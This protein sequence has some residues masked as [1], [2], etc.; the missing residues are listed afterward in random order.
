MSAPRELCRSERVFGRLI[1]LF[2]RDFHER[3][4]GEMAELFRDQLRG[5]RAQGGAPAVAKLWLRT[6][7][8]FAAAALHEHRDARRHSPRTRTDGMLT[9]LSGDLRFAARM[10]RKS[11]LFTAIAVLCI[12]LGSGA[13][14]TI[15]STMNAMVLR[16]M[17]GVTDP[18][19]LMR[20]ERT[21]P[22]ADGFASLPY[23]TYERLRDNARS[24][25]GVAAWSKASLTVRHG[26]GPGVAAYGNYVSGNFFSVFGVR[27]YLGRF[28][29][30]EED[31]AAGASPVIV[32]SESFW[33]ARLGADSSLVGRDLVVN[34]HRFTLV[35]VAPAAFRGPDEP[36]DTQAWVPLA[37]RTL[38]MPH[39]SPLSDP[40]VTILRL[41]GR[42]APGVAPEAARQELQSLTTALV[43]E[44]VEPEWIRKRKDVALSPMTALPKDARAA[45]TGFLGLLLGAATL[46]LLIAGVNVAALLSARAIARRREMAVRAALG[47]ARGRLLRQLLT[48]ILVLFTLGAAGGAAIAV[49]ATNALERLPIPAE[50]PFRLELSPD[51]RVF[52]FALTVSLAAGLVVGLAPARR[53]VRADVVSQL[54]DGTG[55]AS[56]RRSRLGSAL[57]VGQLALSLLLLVGAGLFVQALR[58]GARVDTGFD[59]RGVVVAQLSTDTWGYDQPKARAF[60]AA[61]RARLAGVHGVEAVSYASMLPL[62]LRASGNDVR[63][64][65]AAP[66]AAVESQVVSAD[67]DYFAVLRIPIVA[68]RA[69]LARDDAR[70]PKVVVVNQTLARR[71]VP[72]GEAV[73]RTLAMGEERFTIVGIARDAKQVSLAEKP[74][75][76]AY[77]PLAQRW[78]PRPAL[79]VR[80]GCPRS[81]GGCDPRAVAGAV[82]AAVA[83][84]DLDVPRPAVPALAEAM[85]I[86]LLP[87]R[88]AA[89][90]TGALGGVGLLLAI[91]GLYGIVA[92]SASRRTKEI[93]IRLALGARGA[94]VLR[95]ILREG[96]RLTTAGVTIGLVLAAAATRLLASLLV[97][98]SPLDGVAFGATAAVFVAVALLASW[99]PARRAAKASPMSV[100]R[101]E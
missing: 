84:I 41:A 69:M 83:S 73:G 9:T 48:E 44:G 27:P 38:L 56:A 96:V 95:M 16:P 18:G 87:Q 8:A 2:P 75:A 19:R 45:V 33:R 10:L 6:L 77:F 4:G 61:L 12:S 65:G 66:D 63:I 101:S 88:V 59:A 13:V 47:A 85:S 28:F 46:V 42:L 24:M 79:M 7:P 37:T 76:V 40:G 11:P 36:I 57:V 64:D 58:H 71:L 74:R 17:P 92:Y 94:D 80:A 97:G 60:T 50:I 1:R 93:G 81:A 99:L 62:T 23:A 22:R 49:M 30:P 5:A 29:V 100:L 31:R 3:F 25:A 34:G 51:P 78:D 35:G 21:E 43:A 68:G 72:G 70:A 15:F 89:M 53:A 55:G 32:V 39:A 67:A 90:V 26:G 98:V 52:L 20:I 86:G 54:R 14:T 91:V 82:Q